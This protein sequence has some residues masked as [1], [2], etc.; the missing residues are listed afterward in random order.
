MGLG[1]DRLDVLQI[2]APGTRYA[3]C[4]YHPRIGAHGRPP[5][6]SL[7]MGGPDAINEE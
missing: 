2:G 5:A 7:T 4:T 6:T 1:L 3:S